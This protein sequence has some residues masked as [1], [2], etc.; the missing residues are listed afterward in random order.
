MI[1]LPVNDD[2]GSENFDHPH[3]EI[4]NGITLQSGNYYIEVELINKHAGSMGFA[5]RCLIT[6]ITNIPTLTNPSEECCSDGIIS[7]KKILDYDCNG[8]INDS[9][10]SCENWTYSLFSANGSFLGSQTTNQWGEATFSGL[11]SGN[12]TVTEHIQPGWVC[13][14]N[15][16]SAA[17]EN[18]SGV[19]LT[20]FNCPSSPQS[21]LCCQIPNFSAALSG[22]NLNDLILTI[23]SGVNQIQEVEV[24]M[25]DYHATYSEPG[26][27]PVNMD[28]SGGH[29]GYMTTTTNSLASLNLVAGQNNSHVLDWIPGSPT[30]LNHTV[31]L[32]VTPPSV[33][34]V[35]CCSVNFWFCIKVRVKDIDCKVCEQILCYPSTIT[36]S[37]CQCGSWNNNAIVVTGYIAYG[38]LTNRTPQQAKTLGSSVNCGDSITLTQGTYSISAPDFNCIPSNCI[39]TYHW[40]VQGPVSGSGNGNSFNFN[41]S[42]SGNYTVTFTPYCG[43]QPCEPCI[44]T[45]L[46]N[47]VIDCNCQGG[48]WVI[49]KPTT[50]L[51]E[52]GIPVGSALNGGTMSLPS[53]GPIHFMAP[54]YICNPAPPACNAEYTWKVEGPVSDTGFGPFPNFDFNFTQPG[55][56]VVII[57]ARCGNEDCPR[58]V[59]NVLVGT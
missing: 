8:E 17:I 13:I 37:T 40:M 7:I 21:D 11:P 27:Q 43:T 32:A 15:N 46:I 5:F 25:V 59:F 52:S 50:A 31:N 26:C 6:A 18:G 22:S 14:N 54:P 12:Y 1:N 20:F 41:F 42:L 4:L 49:N 55:N 3:P 35:S 2:G 24:S 48:G 44:I 56:Y 38:T 53:P 16:Q 30:L 29:I 33:I 28:G 34:N 9:D 51:N 47:P 45:I 23:N 58:F 39:A 36:T 10:V 57:T 19:L